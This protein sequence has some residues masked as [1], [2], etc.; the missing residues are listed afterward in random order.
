MMKKNLRFLSLLLA[1]CLTISSVAILASCDE[2]EEPTGSEA[3]G[4]ET[5]EEKEEVHPEI[6]K[7][8][9]DDEFYLHILPDVNPV[10][11][12]WVEESKNDIVSDAVYSRQEKIHQHIGVEIVGTA[13]G[14]FS[15]YVEPFKT[16][17]KNKD[18]SVD[19][20][21]SHVHTGIDGLVGENY[22]TDFNDVP[23]VELDADYW[24]QEFM[25]NISL[26]DHMYL[27]FNNFNILY[28]YVIAFNKVM[29]DKYDDNFDES[30]YDMVTNY[31]WT[32]DKMTSI[33]SL[34]YIDKTNDGKTSDDTFGIAGYQWV[35]FCGFLHSSNINLVEMDSQGYYKVSVYN[36]V[37]REKTVAL[38]DK[39]SALTLT[40]YAWFK[41]SASDTIGLGSNRTLFNLMAT[42]SLS[43]LLDTDVEFGV[44]PY[45]MWDENQKDVGYRS[46]Q[47]GGYICIPSYTRD[48]AM[49]GDTI[50]LLAFYSDDVADAY[51]QKL[52]G[53]QVADSPQDKQMLELIWD[54]IC[55]DFGQTYYSV[56]VDTSLLY[57]VPILTSESYNDE[58]ASFM[59]KVDKMADKKF[60]Q[61][62]T[63]T[64]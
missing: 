25:E 3:T 39:L 38:I 6:G 7:K 14:N 9:Y 2:K 63:K 35:P 1:L 44:L 52:L 23:G 20:L 37:N 19:T 27:G 45:P 49:V 50:E 24:N 57:M 59:A 13:T 22:L 42:V 17:V 58:I 36:D 33:A 60:K 48:I 26:N 62:I 41:S 29:L 34:A 61:F 8:N 30:V 16:A 11:C 4:T 31:H 15:V 18:G 28:T 12:Y 40:D 53:K 43:S 56:V 47:W 46:L 55:S 10:G 32:L 51:Y 5:G 21:I 54:S 64:K